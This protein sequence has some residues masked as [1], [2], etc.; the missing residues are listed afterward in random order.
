MRPRL[1]TMDEAIDRVAASLTAVR[2][3][4]GFVARLETRLDV[5][6][7]RERGLWLVAAPATAAVILALVISFEHNPPQRIPINPSAAL[8][9]DA[10]SVPA[11]GVIAPRVAAEQRVVRVESELAHAAP[12]TIRHLAPLNGPPTLNVDALVV[13]SLTIDPVTEPG[14]LEL[15]SLEVRDIDAVADQKEQ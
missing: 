1:E 12:D 6:S 14:L 13:E 7:C 10:P 2:D 4:E 15:P 11:R 9:P 3:D 8:A 5:R